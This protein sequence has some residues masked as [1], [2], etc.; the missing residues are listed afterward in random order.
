MSILDQVKE[1]PYIAGG[2]VIAVIIV[3]VVFS[4]SGQPAGASVPSGSDNTLSDTMAQVNA[5]VQVASIAAQSHS[6]DVAGAKYMAELQAQT[7][8]GAN[9]LAAELGRAQIT[10]TEH[11][12]TLAAQVAISAQ[13][14]QTQQ[15]GIATAAQNENTRIVANALTT[16]ATIANQKPC[17]TSSSFFG[18]F[19]SKTC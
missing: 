16:E 13:A 11:Q 3:F 4:S 15:L 14:N 6:E 2:A 12:D 1:H 5:N 18:L 8:M 10:A 19:K 17:S 9:A 7:T